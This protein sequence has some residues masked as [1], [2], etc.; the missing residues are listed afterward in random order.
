MSLTSS[1]IIKA[2]YSAI[3]EIKGRRYT[4]K[5][6]AKDCVSHET[7]LSTIFNGKRELGKDL[8]GKISTLLNIHGIDVTPEHILKAR[9][10]DDWELL[11][12]TSGGA[13]DNNATEGDVMTSILKRLVQIQESDPELLED[14]RDYVEFKYNK[15]QSNIAKKNIA[16]A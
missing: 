8:A 11:P 13:I 10:T 15:S 7:Y 6:F 3:R 5:E 14:I 9:Y 16:D 1:E 2:C 12:A 4:Q